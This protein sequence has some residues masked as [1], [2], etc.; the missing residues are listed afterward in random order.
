MSWARILGASRQRD[1]GSRKQ[2]RAEAQADLRTQSRINLNTG[3]MLRLL[4][5][6]VERKETR[7][8]WWIWWICVNMGD[9]CISRFLS[10]SGIDSYRCTVRDERIVD[11]EDSF[12]GLFSRLFGLVRN[13]C[14]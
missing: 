3:L 6:P 5:A 14:V 11:V 2:A 7:D 8:I 9:A 4:R 12:A 13:E 1:H 10:C